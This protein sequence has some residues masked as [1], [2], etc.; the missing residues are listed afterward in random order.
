MFTVDGE[1]VNR[2]EVFEQSD[3]DTALARFDQLS[4]PAPGLENAASQVTERFAV[5][6]TA[7]RLGRYRRNCRPMTSAVTI[8]VEWSARESARSG[9]AYGGHA[10]DE[11]KPL[12]RESFM[13][14]IIATRGE[15]LALMRTHFSGSDQG[16]R[17]VSHRGVRPRR[18]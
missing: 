17:S 14:T 13:K 16:P 15:R 7:H 9:R 18:D 8:A 3:L 6:L 11:F 2:T 1:L 4:Q 12:D 5:H 10:N